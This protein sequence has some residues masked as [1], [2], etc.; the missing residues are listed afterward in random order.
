MCCIHALHSQFWRV[1]WLGPDVILIH[2]FVLKLSSACGASIPSSPSSKSAAG[3]G[4]LT[5][6]LSP[7]YVN[8]VATE[9]ER[10]RENQMAREPRGCHLTRDGFAGSAKW[11][12][13]ICEV[14][15]GSLIVVSESV[16]LKYTSRLLKAGGVQ[17]SA[18]RGL[19]WKTW[20]QKIILWL[21][22]RSCPVIT[23][24]SFVNCPMQIQAIYIPQQSKNGCPAA[25]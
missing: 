12:H 14:L 22:N 1:S 21:S 25:E 18:S 13:Q 5:E 20:N 9:R 8:P 3:E 17:H 15:E 7:C 23:L 4:D 10:E 6:E 24:C 19:G 16:K 11:Q 2:P